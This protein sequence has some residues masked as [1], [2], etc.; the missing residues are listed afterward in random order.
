[1]PETVAPYFL[2]FPKVFKT[3]L[4]IPT[5][6]GAAIGGYAG[7]GIPVARL[8]AQVSDQLLTHPNVLNGAM[9]YWSMPN[10]LYIEGYGL[11]QFCRGNWALRPVRANRVGVLLD[12]G[13]SAEQL[14]HHQNV[15]QAAQATLGLRIGPI[16]TTDEAVQLEL[17][18]GPSGSS[19]GNIQNPGTLLRAGTT[20]KEQGAEAIALV[21]RFPELADSDY[22]QGAGVDPIA[23]L[24]A[25]LS[26][27][28]VRHLQIPVAHAPALTPSLPQLAHPR[29]SAESLGYTFLPSVLVGLSQ[30]PQYI[31][32]TLPTDI[33]EVDVVVLPAG[34]FGG[35]GILS[36]AQRPKPPIFIGVTENTTTVRVPAQALGIKSFTVA[37]YWEAAGL[38][39]TIRAGIDPWRV[40]G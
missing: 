28:L 14:I 23:G 15:L 20:L 10:T 36:L 2:E 22:D 19:W 12:R 16:A 18:L 32:S 40:R 4:I 11:D 8:L 9:L 39:A 3:L 29:T 7:D 26:H 17:T 6:L 27:L 24:E 38:I 37:N 13:L 5:G 33:T 31:T 1:V 34:A 25:L 21:V 35:R 30:A